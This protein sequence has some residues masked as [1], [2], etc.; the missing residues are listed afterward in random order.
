MPLWK[1]YNL[2]VECV[3]VL[4][5]LGAREGGPYHSLALND[6]LTLP[7]SEVSLCGTG[8]QEVKIQEQPRS[9]KLTCRTNRYSTVQNIYT[10]QKHAMFFGQVLTKGILKSFLQQ[11][12]Q[13]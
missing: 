5:G 8:W 1:L 12:E 4:G 10:V 11:T 9:H 2:C 3:C 13:T 7:C 6:K